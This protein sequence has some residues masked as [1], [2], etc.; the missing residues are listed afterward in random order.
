M[1][2]SSL[3]VFLPCLGPGV[4]PLDT[5]QTHQL[6]VIKSWY[7]IRQHLERGDLRL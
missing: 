2:L 4:A 7:K 5:I 1:N 6:R 3:A